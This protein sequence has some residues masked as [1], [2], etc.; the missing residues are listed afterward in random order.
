[1]YL[2]D[3]VVT[4]V[5]QYL[6]E[7]RLEEALLMLVFVEIYFVDRRVDHAKPN[8]HQR[9]ARQSTPMDLRRHRSALMYR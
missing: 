1:M 6:H 3:T 9:Q 8:R 4:M 7:I 2:G 5:R